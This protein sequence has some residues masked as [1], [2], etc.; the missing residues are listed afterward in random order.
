[1]SITTPNPPAYAELVCRSNFSFLSAASHPQELVN[2]A[3]ELEYQAIALTDE[4]SLAGVV[5][6][7]EEQRRCRDRGIAIKLIPGMLI[8]EAHWLFLIQDWLF[9]PG[10]FFS[11]FSSFFADLPGS[12][13]LN[14]LKNARNP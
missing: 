4:C 10:W 2:R 11:W 9:G 8:R 13:F 3:A 12:P 6:A 7:L 14:P 1:M 5:R